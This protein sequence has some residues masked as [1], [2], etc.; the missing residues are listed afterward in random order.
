MRPAAPSTWPCA[1]GGSG[2]SIPPRLRLGWPSRSPPCRAFLS[3]LRRCGGRTTCVD[4]R[5]FLLGA[6]SL[7]LAPRALAG[8]RL[9]P[10]ALVTADLEARLV[11]VDL[12]SGRVRRHVPTEPKP[13]SIEAVGGTAVVAH[14]ELGVVTLLRAA[15][16]TVTHVLHGFGE[17]RY[18][19][20]HPDGRHAFVTDAARG[21]VVAV[22]VLRGRVVGRA[23]VG[24]RARHVTIDPT[25]R[26]L[27]IALGSKAAEVAIV[28][29]TRPTR[30]RLVR[31]LRPPFLAHDVAWAP[32]GRTVWVSSGD[33]NALAL[34]R[35]RTLE[36]VARPPAD[37]PPQHVTF[38]GARAYV[39]SGWTG[40][41]RVYGGDGSSLRRTI[42]PVGSYNVQ[43]A[44]GWVVTPGLGT[45][46]L[47]VVDPRGRL[48]HRERIARSSHDACVV[49]VR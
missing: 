35:A 46:S 41:L 9:R 47:C 13:R 11:A 6:A 48:L 19:A 4:R 32:D 3:D 39:T 7:A 36:V 40:S 25:G 37:W 24:A 15:T 2:E 5:A 43:Q 29:V 18:T 26:R 38:R 21:E 22:D 8:T 30:P 20:G 49:H 12:A 14:S 45:G 44:D 31:L 42:V 27:W 10:L 23:D 34:Y 17:P 1:G 33:R 16:L 28:D